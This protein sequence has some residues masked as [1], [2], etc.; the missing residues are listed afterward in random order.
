VVYLSTTLSSDAGIVIRCKCDPVIWL[1]HQTLLTMIGD[2]MACTLTIV[3]KD[4]QCVGRVAGAA[5]GRG[6][7]GASVVGDS[8]TGA[9]VVGAYVSEAVGSLEAVGDSVVGSRVMGP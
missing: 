9:R 3:N 6:V 7:E 8:V 5:V 2:D 1:G 4:N